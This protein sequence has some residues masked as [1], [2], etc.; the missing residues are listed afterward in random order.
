LEDS[1]ISVVCISDDPSFAERLEALFDEAMD[2]VRVTSAADFES[3]IDRIEDDGHDIAILDLAR[4]ADGLADLVRLN[5]QAPAIPVVLIADRAHEA[6][7]MKAVQIGAQD[8]LLREQLHGT[9]LVRS[10]RYAIERFRLLSE[11]ERRSAAWE[12]PEA[13]PASPAPTA[14]TSVLYGSA[15]LRDALPDVFED[16]VERYAEVLDLVLEERAFRVDHDVPARLRTQAD[17]LG[18]LRAGPRDVVEIH[19]TAIRWLSRSARAERV[20]HYLAEGR[21]L[22]VEL[23]GD[24]VS[25]YRRHSFGARPARVPTREPN[26]PL[27]REPRE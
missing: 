3:A 25:Y 10:I 27:P 12:G 6:L 7:A 2:V 5:A 24:L 16:H 19:T 17:E 22:I 1:T 14:V 20:R 15:P 23:M 8:Y 21:L 18:F 26:Q 4:D 11:L 13:D 9:L